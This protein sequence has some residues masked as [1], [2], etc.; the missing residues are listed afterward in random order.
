M[1]QAQGPRAKAQGPRPKLNP[2][3]ASPEADDNGG[4]SGV[5]GYRSAFAG[6]EIA[7]TAV[8]TIA[9]QS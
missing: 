4:V 6:V 5:I 1:T 8:Q 2:N 7:T 3:W 9:G